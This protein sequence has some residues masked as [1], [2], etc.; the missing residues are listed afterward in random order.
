MSAIVIA[1]LTAYEVKPKGGMITLESPLM[2]TDR[3]I[4][5]NV[6]T[7]ARMLSRRVMT[8]TSLELDPPS[9][10]LALSAVLAPFRGADELGSCQPWES[11]N[12]RGRQ[13]EKTIR[14]LEN[15][16]CIQALR[17]N[18][19]EA[20]RHGSFDAVESRERPSSMPVES[21]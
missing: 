5:F 6:V 10:V 17:S 1:F 11:S 4:R 21:R 3:P 20:R 12:K 15:Q 16:I 14:N 2:R 19:V 18:P 8:G 9:A 13:R 7:V